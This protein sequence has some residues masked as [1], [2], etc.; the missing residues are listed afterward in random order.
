MVYLLHL[1]SSPR[2][3]SETPG[4]HQSVTRMLT[5]EFVTTWK[6]T[7]SD[8]TVTYRDLGHNTV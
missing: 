7:H 3:F 2:S 1:D 4:S 6:A 5:Q 8:G